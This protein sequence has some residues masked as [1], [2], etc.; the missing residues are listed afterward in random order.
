[1]EKSESAKEAAGYMSNARL[2]TELTS[3]LLNTRA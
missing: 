2:S 1:M 3:G